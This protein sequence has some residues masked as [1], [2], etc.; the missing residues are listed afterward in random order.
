MTAN[1]A[2]KRATRQLAASKG[3]SYTEAL[4]GATTLQQLLQECSAS[5]NEPPCSKDDC[6]C[7]E[8]WTRPA[9][10]HSAILGT[11]IPHGTVLQLAGK[12]SNR[13]RRRGIDQTIT[14][15]K[16]TPSHEM[17]VQAGQRR[18][19]LGINQGDALELC[20]SR[21]CPELIYEL[22][23][24]PQHLAQQGMEEVLRQASNW[25]CTAFEVRELNEH[26]EDD[27]IRAALETGIGPEKIARVLAE[28]MNEDLERA[29]IES[30]SDEDTSA[31]RQA[32]ERD[33]ARLEAT[34]RELD[35]ARR[36]RRAAGGTGSA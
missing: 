6:V 24:C 18:F 32:I 4:R 30:W 35:E 17:T 21:G 1:R 29:D 16:A 10:Y 26:M 27:L 19:M 5:P 23:C 31:L 8:P 3:I 22:P 34:A 2:R 14:I 12:L 33:R 15:E 28:R 7:S 13:H 36:R 9:G 11:F 20:A 25:A